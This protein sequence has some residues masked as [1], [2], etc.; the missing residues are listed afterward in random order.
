MPST[1]ELYNEPSKMC[2]SGHDRCQGHVDVQHLR[3]TVRFHNML[4]LFAGSLTE[5]ALYIHIPEYNSSHTLRKHAYA[6]FGGT[7]AITAPMFID[8]CACAMTPY[9]THSTNKPTYLRHSEIPA[10]LPS[11]LGE[12]PHPLIHHRTPHR[13]HHDL[14]LKE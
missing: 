14:H 13:T 6:Q 8:N 12:R 7:G 10:N 1:Q 3:C 11:A 4:T 2:S 5:I 9:V